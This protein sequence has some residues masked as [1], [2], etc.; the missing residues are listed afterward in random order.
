MPVAG[1]DLKR[2]AAALRVELRRRV[3]GAQDGVPTFFDNFLRGLLDDLE[4]TQG[5]HRW[6]IAPREG[7]PA[8]GTL[9]WLAAYVARR[10]QGRFVS[11]TERAQA[12]GPD[13]DV[14]LPVLIM[15]QGAPE[16]LM[17][18]GRPLFKTAFDAALVPMLLWELRPATIFEIG[19]GLGT[20]ALWMAEILRGQ[21]NRAMVHALDLRAL[22]SEDSQVRFHR[23]DCR[24]PAR[25]FPDALLAEAPHPWLVIE[26]AHVNVAAV[27]TRMDR[28]MHAGDY[29]IVEDSLPKRDV[30]AA[31]LATCPAYRV[32]TRYTDYFG[33]NATAAADAILRRMEDS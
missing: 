28:F 30:L 8:L 24:D 16:C 12:A 4:A 1:Q 10:A 23:G 3:A 9:R 29:L 2:A 14:P 31:F 32:D 33:R 19:A 18:K 20:S 25:L 7:E 21:D 11:W 27:L 6:D 26:D 22:A 5:R 17:W 15:S 13:S